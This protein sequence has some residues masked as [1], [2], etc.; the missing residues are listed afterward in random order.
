MARE[1]R[2]SLRRARPVPYSKSVGGYRSW[3]EH[4]LAALAE[5]ALRLH[6]CPHEREAV[7]ALL[8][9]AAVVLPILGVPIGRELNGGKRG[10]DGVRIGRADDAVAGRVALVGGL[11]AGDGKR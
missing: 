2:E 6:G 9:R 3:P 7:D 5:D 10:R 1:S 8:A 4:V 11:V